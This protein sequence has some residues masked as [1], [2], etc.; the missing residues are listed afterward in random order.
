MPRRKL[1]A[2]VNGVRIR[3][4]LRLGWMDGVKVTFDS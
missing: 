4:R 3:S 2:E 1:M